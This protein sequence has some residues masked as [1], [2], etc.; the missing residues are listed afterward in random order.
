MI[1]EN[2][3][4]KPK[5]GR[6]RMYPPMAGGMLDDG[7]QYTSRHERNQH[8]A[9]ALYMLLADRANTDLAWL[10]EGHN[11]PRFRRLTILAE[12]G[13]LALSEHSMAAIITN[14]LATEFCTTKPTTA[15]ALATIRQWRRQMS[16]K[17]QP[18][19]SPKEL[20]K[21]LIRVINDYIGMHP[22]IDHNLILD[23]LRR[24]ALNVARAQENSQ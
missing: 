14:T 15:Q 13:R 2:I 16:G 6:P 24:T 21:Q 1:S 19:G 12:L 20:A 7:R 5:R 10:F 23:A 9:F 11:T 3:S 4:E 17:H 18:T 8:T 22:G